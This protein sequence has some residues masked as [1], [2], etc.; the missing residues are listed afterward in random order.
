MWCLLYCGHVTNVSHVYVWCTLS[1]ISNIRTC[2][3]TSIIW[4]IKMY[5]HGRGDK[6]VDISALLES[7]TTTY[8]P[9]NFTW[10]LKYV[11]FTGK[12]I[13][14]LHCF[15]CLPDWCHFCGY[16][17]LEQYRLS[18]REF[19]TV[20]LHTLELKIFHQTLQYTNVPQ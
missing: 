5:V 8:K 19:Y 15:I 3:E 18:M 14:E 6:I 11:N 4:L 20:M 10:K 1:E 9:W 12:S 13:N 17:H 2:T 16:L 7:Q